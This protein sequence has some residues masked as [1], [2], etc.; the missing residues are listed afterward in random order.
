MSVLSVFC[1]A[2][3]AYPQQEQ[4]TTNSI[5]V[6]LRLIPA[7]S[8]MMGASPNESE[9]DGNENPSRQIEIR[10]PYY[11]E[12]YE[13]TQEQYERVMGENPS[14]FKGYNRTVE[15]VSWNDAVA[16]YRKLSE[17]TGEKYRLPTEAEWEYA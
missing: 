16:F 10:K 12:T 3:W 15:S 5:G 7:Y 8:F 14:Q 13:V 11:I 4:K 1:F 17:L 6:R 2:S 9:A